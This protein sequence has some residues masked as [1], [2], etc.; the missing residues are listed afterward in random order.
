LANSGASPAVLQ[1]MLR[2]TDIKTTLR[3]YVHA[4]AEVQRA[5]LANI[6][7]LQCNL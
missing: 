6:Q 4:D 5:A 1:R 2:H 3:L 7:S